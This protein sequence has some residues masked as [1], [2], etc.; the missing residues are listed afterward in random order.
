M[1]TVEWQKRGLPHVHI[2]WWLEQQ[3]NQNMI[4]TFI[5]AELPNPSEDPILFAIV[6]SNMIHG[7]CW[8]FNTQSL[9]TK[10]GKCA[11]RYPKRFTH[12]TQ[13]GDDGY[14]TYQRRRVD[15]GGI[16]FDKIIK[17]N[18]VTID[19]RWVVPYCPVLCRTFK[20]HKNVEFCVSVK[21]IK[22]ICKYINKGSDQATFPVQNENDEIVQFQS[23]RYVS[24]SEAV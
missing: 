6:S 2:L 17:Q 9:C 3:L 7:P 13:T 4:D 19:N 23:G 11:K 8:A 21:S 12:H 16:I 24:S 14:P 18:T 10:Y 20:A 1:Y 22:Y 15:D 5:S